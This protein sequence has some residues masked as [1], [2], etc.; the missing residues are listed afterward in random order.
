MRAGL[1][2]SFGFGLFVLLIASPLLY[3]T[4]RQT[5]RRHFRVVHDGRLYRSGAMDFDEFRRFADE[6]RI[7]TVINL[8]DVNG[9][10]DPYP[11]PDEEKYCRDLG[12][13]YVRLPARSWRRDADG[14]IAAEQNI[15]KILDVCE[16]EANYPI[17]IHCFS[18]EHRTGIA[19][20]VLR[21][22]CDGWS[23]ARAIEEMV[24]LGYRD[25][26]RDR[27]VREYLERYRPRSRR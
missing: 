27:E 5:V 13:L 19:C 10:D 23:N 20:A 21:M 14:T 17:W 2:W 22:E 11:D 18:G 7:R 26:D 1:R 3:L 12:I 6:S 9:P 25:L 16:A 4:Y 24:R 15:R 8:R